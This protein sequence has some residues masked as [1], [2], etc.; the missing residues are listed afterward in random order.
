MSKLNK[1]DLIKTVA[2]E[3]GQTQA[4]TQSILDA[5]FAA[6]KN[7]PLGSSVALNGFG[8]FAMKATKAKSGINRLTGKPY[9]KAAGQKLTFTA[10][11]KAA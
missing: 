8:K 11:G 1:A 6:I 7:A 3:T 10:S 4:A 9:E 5:A 2:N